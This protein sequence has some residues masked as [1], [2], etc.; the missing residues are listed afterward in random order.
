VLLGAGIAVVAGVLVGGLVYLP[1]LLDLAAA[2]REIARKDAQ[3]RRATAL[4]QQRPEV[5]RRYAA[6]RLAAEQLLVRIPRE[7]DL[8]DL[9]L[10]LDE[11][12]GRSGVELMEITFPPQPPAAPAAG[13]AVSVD[14]LAVHARVRGTYPQIRA[15]VAAIEQSSRLLVIDR[16]ALTGT[17][18]GVVAEVQFRALYRR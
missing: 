11:A 5:E 15:L 10:R 1:A 14:A 4:A 17:D 7:P 16:V 2:R 12:I 3:L 13:G 8:P 9:I 6:E 18:G